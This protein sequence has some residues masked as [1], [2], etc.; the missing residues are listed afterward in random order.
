MKIE[1]GTNRDEVKW[2]DVAVHASQT[3]SASK[4]VIFVTA[5]ELISHKDAID[6]AQAGW[7]EGCYCS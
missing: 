3:L 6:H 1:I 7:T 5:N 4:Q 2:T